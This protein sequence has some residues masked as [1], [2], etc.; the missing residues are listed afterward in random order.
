MVPG[1]RIQYRHNASSPEYFD[2]VGARLIRGRIY[3]PEEARDSAPVA[4]IT[5][6]LARDLWGTED[7]IGSSLE[8]I[9]GRDDPPGPPS[10]LW[11]RKPAGTRVIGVVQET[12]SGQPGVPA[13]YLPHRYGSSP[14]LVVRV[15]D[16]TNPAD[17]ARPIH[18]AVRG[19]D[20]EVSR[21]ISLVS[22][23]RERR[24]SGPRTLALL[25]SGAALTALVLAAVGL[26][27]VT[28][29]AVGQRRHEVSVRL[30][31]GANGR[32]VVSML[33]RDSL[34]PVVVGLI[35]GVGLSFF[36][37]RTLRSFMIGISPRDPIAIGAAVTVLLLAAALAAFL[38]ARHA[39]RV[40]PAAMLKQD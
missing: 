8:R 30:A 5:Q 17:I 20:P 18:D 15:Q 24:V 7:P 38:P 40:D 31:L 21:T 13:V 16:G 4:V 2:T 28:A 26:F 19:I 29:F 23:L 14:Y 12:T 32:Q 39:A 10:T 34:R 22:T 6:G 1:T 3:R 33:L 37:D 27:A 25:G 36:A 11:N 9:W 35:G